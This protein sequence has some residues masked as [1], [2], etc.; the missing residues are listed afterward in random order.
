[1]RRDAVVSD[2]GIYR[3]VLTRAWAESPPAC[4]FVMA[5]PSTADASEDD[6]TIRKVL[7]FARRAGFN[8]VD[9][10]NLFAFRATIIDD[11]PQDMARAVGGDLNDG[12]ILDYCQHRTVYV[13]WGSPAKLHPSLRPRIP[14]VLEILKQATDDVR[15]LALNADG[16]PT[17]PARLAYNRPLDRQYF[18]LGDVL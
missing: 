13:A 3:D 5:N 16:S 11:L 15:F 12:F 9:V 7:G 14:A 8:S 6:P 2:D 4:T 18:L 1:M 10:V 17:H